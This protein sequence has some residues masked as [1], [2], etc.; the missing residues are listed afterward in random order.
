MAKR[1]P[2]NLDKDVAMA[3]KLGYGVHYGAYKADHPHTREKEPEEILDQSRF[4]LCLNC[5]KRFSKCGRGYRKLYCDDV[6]RMQ[7][8]SRI[9]YQKAQERRKHNGQS[10]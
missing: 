8:Y 10:L 5:G 6:C 7:Y 9:E 4:G 3:L 1:Q 2:D